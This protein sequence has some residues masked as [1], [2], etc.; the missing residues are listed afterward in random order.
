M[1]RKKNKVDVDDM[2]GEKEIMRGK[3][4]E[5]ERERKT[6][7]EVGRDRKERERERKRGKYAR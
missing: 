7:K 5:G 4:I 3:L 1:R 6:E 2:K